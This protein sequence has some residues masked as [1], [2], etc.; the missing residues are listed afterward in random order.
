METVKRARWLLTRPAVYAGITSLISATVYA[1]DG[2]ILAT[3]GHVLGGLFAISYGK[4][5]A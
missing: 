3:A 2:H 5:H 1:S 4:N